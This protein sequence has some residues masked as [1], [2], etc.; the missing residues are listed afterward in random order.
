MNIT[1]SVIA[2]AIV[3]V[4]QISNA[5][6]P[7]DV[8][9]ASRES[10]EELIQVINSISREVVTAAYVNVTHD[11]ESKNVRI[12]SI[13][14]EGRKAPFKVGGYQVEVIFNPR[15]AGTSAGVD[16]YR[17]QHNNAVLT[18]A[19]AKFASGEKELG[20]SLIKL[21][22]KAEPDLF[23]DM[24]QPVMKIDEIQRRLIK[25]D[26]SLKD[27]LSEKN[28]AWQNIVKQYGS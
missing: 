17:C 20:L 3:L 13:D 5:Q 23:W 21:L 22:A 16:S 6:M 15:I 28:D 18:F 4:S 7:P 25:D 2:I 8:V 9:P 12:F 14:A 24:P 10:K 19:A 1:K 27:F 26:G 11:V